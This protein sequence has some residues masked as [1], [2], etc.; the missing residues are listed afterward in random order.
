MAALKIPSKAP[1]PQEWLL[2]AENSDQDKG[3]WKNKQNSNL[4]CRIQGPSF[5]KMGSTDWDKAL[6]ILGCCGAGFI[7]EQSLPSINTSISSLLDGKWESVS[8]SLVLSVSSA[9]STA[10][11][12][13]TD[14]CLP[15]PPSSAITG[16]HAP[17]PPGPG[18]VVSLRIV[19]HPYRRRKT[20]TVKGWG[21]QSMYVGNPNRLR[22]TTDADSFLSSVSGW[23]HW[24][25]LKIQNSSHSNWHLA[26][27]FPLPE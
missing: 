8:S 23:W 13:L 21:M 1:A 7:E 14:T 2:L 4:F 27:S 19:L 25:I 26:Y 10:G 20:T 15:L 3:P 18:T 24:D 9:L 5:L 11:L 22:V 12:E 17:L 16:M 6:R